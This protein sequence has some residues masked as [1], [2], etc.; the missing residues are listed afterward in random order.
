MSHLKWISFQRRFSFVAQPLSHHFQFLPYFHNLEFGAASKSVSVNLKRWKAVH[1]LLSASKL[2]KDPCC[3]HSCSL[4][5]KWDTVAK[6]SWLSLHMYILPRVTGL[7][8]N[9]HNSQKLFL[10]YLKGFSVF[11]KFP[12]RCGEMLSKSNRPSVHQFSPHFS[13]QASIWDFPVCF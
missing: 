5:K 12:S 4:R 2:S 8:I 9:S 13:V 10:N 1:E 3:F 11:R 7:C 6:S